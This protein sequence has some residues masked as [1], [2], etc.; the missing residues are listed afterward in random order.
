MVSNLVFAQHG[1]VVCT[2]HAISNFE[3][4]FECV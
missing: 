4:G 1:G 3:A 2:K